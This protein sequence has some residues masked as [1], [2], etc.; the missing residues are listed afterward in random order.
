MEEKTG[1]EGYAVVRQNRRLRLGYTTGTCA[2]AAA[3]G[4]AGMLLGGKMLERV[5]LMTPGGILLNL[6]LLD[7]RMDE[8]AVS[9]AVQKDAGDDPDTTDRILVYARVKKAA[10]PGIHLDAG[11]GIGIVTLP[12]LC[13]KVGEPAINPVPCRMIVEAAEEMADRY[14]YEGGLS[15]TI[16]VPEGERIAKKTFNEKLGIMGGIS[17]LGTTGIVEPMSERAYLES[18]RIEMRQ[19]LAQG[20]RL[21]LM[22]PGNYGAEYLRKQASLPFEA[23]IKCS[24]YIGESIDLAA[25]LGA[26]GILFVSHIGKFVK[27]AGGIMNTHSHQADCRMEILAAQVIRSGGTLECAREI[28]EANTTDEAL[29]ILERHK[30]TEPVMKTLTE[31]IQYY[32]DQ[33]SSRRL[34][35]GAVIFSNV[36]GYLGQTRDARALIEQFSTKT[37]R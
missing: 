31:R 8:G 15:V 26:E 36:Y 20:S 25:E 29:G 28:L 30:F 17:I 3:K 5:E 2:A 21:L 6:Q 11:E 7:I 27:V 35:L 13:R 4:A 1:L 9:C 14:E 19:R 16:Y 34:H 18:L 12:G 32:L 23:V 24:N 22:T 10:V 33:R 37:D